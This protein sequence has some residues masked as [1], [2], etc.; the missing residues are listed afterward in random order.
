MRNKILWSDE[1]LSIMFEGNQLCSSPEEYHPI[2]KVHSVGLFF[3]GRDSTEK[4]KSSMYH[5]IE[6]ALMKTQSRAFRNSDWAEGLPSN[7]TETLNHW[8]QTQFLRTV[9]LQ[10]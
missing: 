6:I 8:S 7:M 9:Q 3:S 5:N 4:K 1:P 2:S 10:P